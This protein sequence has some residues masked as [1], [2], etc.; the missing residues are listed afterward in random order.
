MTDKVSVLFAAA[1]IAPIAKVGGLA[2]VVGS[3]PQALQKEGIKVSVAL[4][5]YEFLKTNAEL[6]TKKL[7]EFEIDFKGKTEKVAVFKAKLPKTTVDLLLF[8]RNG[9][10][11]TIYGSATMSG[12][13]YVNPLVDLE[14]FIF[15]SLAV[16]KSLGKLKDKFDIVHCHD[17]HTGL[18]P[19]FLKNTSYK[20]IFTIHNLA[21]QGLVDALLGTWLNYSSLP[22]YDG[23]FNLLATGIEFADS[24][25]TVSPTYA[26]E[27][28]TEEFGC[29]LEK[30]LNK[31]KNKLSGIVNGIDTVFFNPATDKFIEKKY[32][33]ANINKK[34]VNKSALQTEIGLPVGDRA[35]IGLVSRF[36]EQKGLD[37]VGEAVANCDAQFVFLGEGDPVIE[38]ELLGLANDLPEKFKV[39][40]SFNLGLAQKI[41][42]ASDFFLMPSRF[43]PCGLG[44]LIAM[45]YGSLPIVRQVGGLKDTVSSK[46][47]YYFKE[48]SAAVLRKTVDRALT[49]FYAQPLKHET[50]KMTALKGDYSWQKS[51]VKYVKIYK[52]LAKV[53][54]N[55]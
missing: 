25:N 38:K 51:A 50:L 52:K 28:L 40:K 29:G 30:L 55:I 2:D 20:T 32:S 27:I 13:L 15:F 41:Y 36:V 47:G 12:G 19:F 10:D 26:K 37:L 21:N 5:Y 3:L 7:A 18:I 49:V 42:A 23:Q 45:R 17:W 1:E 44:Q 11:A 4:P 34:N 48:D 9:K 8:D 53:K 6:K 35:L 39:I 33:A 14:R 54:G 16:V 46:N 24:V 22:K 31:H 43:E